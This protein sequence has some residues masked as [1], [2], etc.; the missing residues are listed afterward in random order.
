[1]RDWARFY[2]SLCVTSAACPGDEWLEPAGFGKGIW[3]FCHHFRVAWRALCVEG[4]D[5]GFGSDW[6]LGTSGWD[7]QKQQ[8]KYGCRTDCWKVLIVLL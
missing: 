5:L 6:N 2:L 7:F 1:M 4:A 3:L 8:Q